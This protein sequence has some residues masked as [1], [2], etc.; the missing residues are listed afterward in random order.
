MPPFLPLPEDLAIL[1]NL[2]FATWELVKE[3]L[4]KDT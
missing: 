3:I 2:G 1:G 4:T